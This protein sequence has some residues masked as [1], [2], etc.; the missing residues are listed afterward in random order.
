MTWVPDRGIL[1][2][3]SVRAFDLLGKPCIGA[4]YVGRG[5]AHR[6]LQGAQC[7]AC[8]RIADNCHHE[9]PKGM[10]GGGFKLMHRT[11]GIITLR[12]PLVAVCGNGNADGCHARLHSRDVTLQWVWDSDVLAREWAEGRLNPELYRNNP[13]LY[14]YGCYK[15][16]S[17]SRD[18]SRYEVRI[19]RRTNEWRL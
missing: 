4:E 19:I 3:R 12:S 10:G 7:A 8:G 13:D 5:D 18:R 2:G 6:L 9:P 15:L 11:E 14:D 17:W 1:R 16:R